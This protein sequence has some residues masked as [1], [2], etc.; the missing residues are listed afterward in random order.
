MK[1]YQLFSLI[2]TIIFAAVG[3]V[4]LFIPNQ[5]LVFFN[6]VSIYLGMPQSPVQGAN[7][8]LILAVAYM[9]T[10]T[11]LAW[12]MYKNPQEKKYPFLLA[13]AKLASAVVSLYLFV[14][15][16]PYLIYMTNCVVDGCIGLLALYF[17]QNLHKLKG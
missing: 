5:V 11:L 17:L 10:V 9:Y 15:Y 12:A 1:F 14:V 8:Y 7:F 3:L 2:L 13:N 16:Q 4:F 6:Y